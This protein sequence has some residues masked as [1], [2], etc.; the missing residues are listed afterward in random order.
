MRAY[1][2]GEKLFLV[3]KMC[4]LAAQ[5]NNSNSY[6]ADQLIS[7]WLTAYGRNSLNN[8]SWMTDDMAEST[9]NFFLE[10][11]FVSVEEFKSVQLIQEESL[12]A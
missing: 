7:S 10:I 9:M 11:N 12:A 6:V 8:I 3:T 1:N 4:K 2:N 5:S